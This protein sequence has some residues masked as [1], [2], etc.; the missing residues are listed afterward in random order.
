M[1]TPDSRSPFTA[2]DWALLWLR[3]AGSL[4]LLQVHGL[5]KL[6]QFTEQLSLIEDPWHLGAK[7]TLSLAIFAEVLCPLPIM[8]G[9]FTRLACLPIL[10]VLLVALVFVHPE[11][12]LAEGQFAWLLAL[13]FSTVFIAG[14]GRI[15]LSRRLPAVVYLQ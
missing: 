7:L 11:W 3:V 8:L 2:C 1:A 6:L 5:P 13:V 4:L 9:I 10:A 15:A 12:S 14:P